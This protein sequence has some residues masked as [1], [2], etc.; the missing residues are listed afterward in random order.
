MSICQVGS[1]KGRH[2]GF[3]LAEARG[4]AQRYFA[5]SGEWGCLWDPP[6]PQRWEP[7]TPKGFTRAVFPAAPAFANGGNGPASVC[8]GFASVIQL[9]AG[10]PS[11]NILLDMSIHEL[12][13]LDYFSS[14][15]FQIF[16]IGFPRAGSISYEIWPSK[17]S[18]WRLISKMLWVNWN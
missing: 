9:S 5:C 18:V 1:L 16:A 2:L 11:R 10:S 13:P 7:P 6:L 3:V 14:W 15:N 8:L 17:Y 12:R 4:A